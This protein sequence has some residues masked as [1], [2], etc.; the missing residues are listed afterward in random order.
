MYV[1]MRGALH[2]ASRFAS[3]I[4]VV[5]PGCLSS[6]FGLTLNIQG[7]FPSEKRGGVGDEKGRASW[8]KPVADRLPV[9]CGKKLSSCRR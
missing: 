1:S 3:A 6:H 5:V 4:R 2:L 7:G 8:A 9:F